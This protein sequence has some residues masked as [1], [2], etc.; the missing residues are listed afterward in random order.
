MDAINYMTTQEKLNAIERGYRGQIAALRG[1]EPSETYTPRGVTT[2]GATS[3]YLNRPIRTREQAANELIYEA[4]RLHEAGR[5][6]E[7]ARMAD[8]AFTLVDL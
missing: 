8:R 1:I 6:E 3:P 4:C 2:V 5:F 7:A